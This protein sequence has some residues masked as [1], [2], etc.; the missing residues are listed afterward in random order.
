LVLENTVFG[1]A[2]ISNGTNRFKPIPMSICSIKNDN[3]EFFNYADGFKRDENDKNQYVSV[4]GYCHINGTEFYRLPVEK[5]YEYHVSTKTNDLF[6][7]EKIVKGQMFKGKLIGDA[8]AI[9]IFLDL[10][11]KRNNLAYIGASISAQYGK[12]K[13]VFDEP[14]E[15]IKPNNI[16][17]DVVLEL[18]SDA[19]IYDTNGTNVANKDSLLGEIRK[20]AFFYESDE[21][22]ADER[23][24][25]ERDPVIYSKNITIGGFNATWKLP[26]PQYSA[27]AKGTVVELYDFSFKADSIIPSAL[28]AFSNIGF[29]EYRIREKSEISKSMHISKVDNVIITTSINKARKIEEAIK[30]NRT[31]DKNH[32][33]AL[34]AANTGYDSIKTKIKL[35]GAKRFDNLF[36]IVLKEHK[37]NVSKNNELNLK[38]ELINKVESEF[39]SNEDIKRYAKKAIQSFGNQNDD[40]LFERY[41]RAYIGQVKRRYQQERGKTD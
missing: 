25:D 22:G 19:I 11:Q 15:I 14:Y 39:E 5:A 7:Y 27:F 23:D 4:S 30:F 2:Y 35:S 37:S 41:I 13:L 18:L 38:N 8:K 17:G 36:S 31:Q 40:R 21:R 6:S 26:R 16:N 12:V 1:N 29:G 20:V 9:D 10:M 3:N 24:P 32:V 34:I 33:N 28:G